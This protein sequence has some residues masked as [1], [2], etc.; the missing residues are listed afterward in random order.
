[1][2]GRS[3]QPR[4]PFDFFRNPESV[5]PRHLCVQH[6]H[7]KRSSLRFGALQ[8]PS[9]PPGRFRIPL[10][11]SARPQLF[12]GVSVDSSSCRPQSGRSVHGALPRRWL[13]PSGRMLLH[14]ESHREVK[15]AA[16]PDLAFH[17]DLSAHHV[18]EPR[19]NRQPQSRPAILAGHGA[20][21][22]CELLKNNL[23]AFARNPD[24]RISH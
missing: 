22:L 20:V 4:I 21:S 18:Y 16:P 17:P 23:L 19:G 11:S 7:R 24:A 8:G 13:I 15:R 9:A 3:G 1:M 6:D 2:H 5:H 12:P 10:V 14:L